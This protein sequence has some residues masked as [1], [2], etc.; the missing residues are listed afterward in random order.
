MCD[1]MISRIFKNFHLLWDCDFLFTITLHLN[2]L[3]EKTIAGIF[4]ETLARPNCSRPVQKTPATE[5]Q[6]PILLC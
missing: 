2:L 1:F 6:L 5:H 3:T 4:G